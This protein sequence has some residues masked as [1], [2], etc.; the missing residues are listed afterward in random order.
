MF[1]LESWQGL[2]IQGNYPRKEAQQ[3]HHWP[4]AFFLAVLR[5]Y[6][7][8]VIKFTDLFIY[9]Y[10]YLFIYIYLEPK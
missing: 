1:C 2:G 9:L 4:Q 6:Y 5:V 8:H 10:I 3:S 7:E